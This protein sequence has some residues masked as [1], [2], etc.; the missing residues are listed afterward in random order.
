[1]MFDAGNGIPRITCRR[2]PCAVGVNAAGAAGSVAFVQPTATNAVTAMSPHN[3]FIR[4]L[5]GVEL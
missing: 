4:A 1:M 2:V 3:R 5:L